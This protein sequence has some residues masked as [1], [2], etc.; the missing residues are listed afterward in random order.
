MCG[1]ALE[2][3]RATLARFF[4]YGA[5]TFDGLA[6]SLRPASPPRSRTLV[7]GG[8]RSGKSRY[9]EKLLNE[10]PK[11]LYVATGMLPDTAD[12]EWAERVRV[13]QERRPP[14]WQTL[15][16]VDIAA[17]LRTADAP[18][19]VDCLATWLTRV[20]DDTGAWEDAPGW[21]QRTDDVVA[22][23]LDAWQAAPTPVVA[24]SNEVG[25][26]IV[27]DTPSGRLFRDE[28]GTLNR[29][30][31]ESAD[32]VVLVVAGRALQLEGTSQ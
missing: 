17:A 25:S 27:P 18:V 16:T 29:R 26:G 20:C 8:A 5:K 32:S 31:A 6:A 10:H 1:M 13:H 23:L 11:V 19:L 15:E 30:I 28:L 21:R 24:V 14:H 3:P 12:P 4:A 7:L 9:A 22:D 2:T